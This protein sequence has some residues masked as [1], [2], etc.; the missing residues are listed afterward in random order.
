M[1]QYGPFILCKN[2][3]LNSHCVLQD[4]NFLAFGAPVLPAVVLKMLPYN[5]RMSTKVQ[6]ILFH[7]WREKVIAY[8]RSLASV[9]D[10]FL[11]LVYIYMA[12]SIP[13]WESETLL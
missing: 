13:L 3:K 9:G 2:L 6:I 1:V 5:V 8:S 7:K 12:I 10:V 4:Y 11:V